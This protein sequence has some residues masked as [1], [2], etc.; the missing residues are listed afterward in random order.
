MRS[1]VVPDA[2]VILKWGF[3]APEERDRDEAA[4]IL[5]AWL[6]GKLAI[7]LPRL[8]AFEVGNVLGLKNPTHARELMDIFIG[9]R[10][11]EADTSS[12]ICHAALA[13]MKK[14]R[15]TFYDAV[16]HAVAL[17]A[18]GLLVTADEVYHRK[19][20]GEGNIVLLRDWSPTP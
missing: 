5:D 10:F 17:L 2:S 14:H 16:Y 18:G 20:R 19:A 11:P 13:L 9:Y 3:K 8:W 7:L 1:L 12:E 6:D 15:V 4:K